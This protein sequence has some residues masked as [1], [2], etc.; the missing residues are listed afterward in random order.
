M[1][2]LLISVV[3]VAALAAPGSAVAQEEP[4][5]DFVASLSGAEEVPP[6]AIA[7]SGAAEFHLGPGNLV[8]YELS[9]ENISGVFA[10][11]IHAPAPRGTNAPVRQFLC[12]GAG[13]P[14]C[15][16]HEVTGS[17]VATPTLLAQ[18]R[19]GLAYVNAHTPPHPGGEIRGQIESDD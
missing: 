7:A 16:D 11:H 18:M 8:T 15:N 12:G 6:L 5:Q 13:T 1:R 9:F 2:R 17:F 4:S 10:A 19:D 14:P 3:A